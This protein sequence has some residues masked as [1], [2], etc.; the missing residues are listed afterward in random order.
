MTER[1]ILV[2]GSQCEAL[3]RLPFL[4]QAAQDLYAVMTD[5]ERGACVSALA[6]DGL[7]IDPTVKDAKDAIK[8]AYQRAAE[9]EA[10]LFIAYIG[11]GE[12]ASRDFYLLPRDAQNP[13]DA[14]TAMHLVNL[15]KE[16][17]RKA[18]GRVDG[19]GMLVDA[20]YS[21]VAGFGAAE[22]WSAELQGTLRFEMLTAAADLPAA[23][24]CFSRTLVRLLRDGGFNGAC[25]AIARTSPA[26]PD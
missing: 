6:G 13:P 16:T 15:I 25:G 21:G 2:I 9:D 19:L 23:D 18:P 12:M 10:T 3:G 8:S 17:H 7:L 20:C 5:P 1:R 14:D 22:V 24:G 26:P 11:H 4:P